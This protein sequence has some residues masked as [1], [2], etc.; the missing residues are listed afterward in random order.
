[1][2]HLSN[3]DDVVSHPLPIQ[4]KQNGWD[5]IPKLK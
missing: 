2:L 4:S 3:G 5:V 1:M